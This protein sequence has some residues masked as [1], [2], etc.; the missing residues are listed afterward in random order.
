ME[1]IEFNSVI[2][3]GYIPVPQEYLN[4]INSTVKVIVLIGDK[5]MP[6]M[7]KKKNLQFSDFEK[8]WAGTFKVSGDYDDAKYEYL[9]EKYK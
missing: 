6:V 7:T 4:K 8:K 1:A 5:E 2:N 9:K 3:N